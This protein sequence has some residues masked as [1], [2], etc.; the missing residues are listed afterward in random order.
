MDQ[1]GGTDRMD[2]VEGAAGVY[3]AD[4]DEPWWGDMTNVDFWRIYVVDEDILP[5]TPTVC[6]PTAPNYYPSESPKDISVR[7]ER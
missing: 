7:D 2:A 6:T 5:G 4:F 3:T 1:Q